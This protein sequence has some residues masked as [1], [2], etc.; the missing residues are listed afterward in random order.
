MINKNV[1]YQDKNTS[2]SRN[3]IG[4][5]NG[6]DMLSIEELL[7]LVRTQSLRFYTDVTNNIFDEYSKLDKDLNKNLNKEKNFS[8]KIT[9][10]NNFLSKYDKTVLLNLIRKVRNTDK[11]LNITEELH[12]SSYVDPETG[13]TRLAV[14]QQIVDFYNIF[15]NKTWFNEFVRAQES[16]FRTKLAAENGDI[17]FDN[18]YIQAVNNS[19]KSRD[20]FTDLLNSLGITQEE[21]KFINS[22]QEHKAYKKVAGKDEFLLN[23]LLK[24]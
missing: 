12:Y 10:I 7:E 24:K 2:K 15:S 1:A 8:K 13:D 21:S 20:G 22:K 17:L 4:N 6:T 16:S 11:T 19:T 9:I 23:P 5:S 18:N 3:I 14:N